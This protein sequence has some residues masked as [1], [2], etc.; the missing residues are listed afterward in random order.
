MD[1]VKYKLFDHIYGLRKYS[2]KIATFIV[3]GLD[4]SK[5]NSGNVIIQYKVVYKG[6]RW[7][8]TNATL[9]SEIENDYTIS[10]NKES[11]VKLMLER[12]QKDIENKQKEYDQLLQQYTHEITSTL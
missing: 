6:N 10:T 5:S 9:L 4:T 11:I 3:V 7:D 1:E 2:N 12:L 8:S